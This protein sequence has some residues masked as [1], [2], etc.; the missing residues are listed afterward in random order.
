[1]IRIISLLVFALLLR[2]N[3][4]AQELEKVVWTNI[5]G[6][7]VNTEGEDLLKTS[8][9]I[10]GVATSHNKLLANARGMVSYT[11]E[12]VSTRRMIALASDSRPDGL[13]NMEHAFYL[14]GEQLMI[15]ENGR[16]IGRFGGYEP[17]M[18]ISIERKEN[19]IYYFRNGRT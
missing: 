16:V 15:I 1:M 13:E 5:E 3:S 12:D 19:L 7:A 9:I 17:G 18:V 6:V 4:Y 2:V 14:S 11:I 10:L 8:P